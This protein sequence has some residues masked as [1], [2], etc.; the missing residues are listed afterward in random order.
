VRPLL[1]EPSKPKNIIYKMET[2]SNEGT[3]QR[4]QGERILDASMV[5]MDLNY[6]INQVQNEAAWKETDRNAVTIFKSAT[7]RIVL[8]GLHRN[9][10]LKTHTAK[11][12]NFSAQEQ[13]VTLQKSQ[14]VALHENIP[15]SVLALEDSFFLLTLSMDNKKESL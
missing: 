11:G 13:T 9:A 1:P 10:E 14:M 8:L 3:P 4:P 12:I 6:F 2:K 5:T 7:M 15:H